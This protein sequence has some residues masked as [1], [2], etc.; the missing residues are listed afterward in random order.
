MGM[1]WIKG[2]YVDVTLE[3]AL[4]DGQNFPGRQE[5]TSHYKNEKDT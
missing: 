5:G 1:R 4:K 2:I 3:L